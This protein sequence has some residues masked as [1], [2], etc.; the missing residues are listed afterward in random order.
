[1]TQRFA[2]VLTVINLVLLVFV[3]AQMRPATAQEVASV[4][5]GRAL[6]IVDGQGRIRA[7]ISIEAPIVVDGQ[8]FPESVLLR[9]NDPNGPRVKIDASSRGT[10][11][12]FSDGSGTGAVGLAA[13]VTGSSV[14]VTSTDGRER[15]LQ[16]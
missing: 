14:K 13:T 5:R 12:R 4:L 6:E 9:M 11:A 3:L 15:L 10:G 8:P 1:M 7:S 16:P 2:V